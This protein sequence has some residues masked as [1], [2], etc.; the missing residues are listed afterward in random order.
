MIRFRTHFALCIVLTLCAVNA[1]ASETRACVTNE[2]VTSYLKSN[3]HWSIVKLSDLS[4]DDQILWKRHHHGLCPGMAPGRLDSGH[5]WY[6]LALLNKTKGK[7]QEKLVL[8]KVNGSKV[9]SHLL[10]APQTIVEPFVVWRTGSGTYLDR[11]TEKQTVIRHDSFIY[12]KMESAS[13]QFYLQDGRIHKL[14]AAY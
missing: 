1:Y 4:I 9:T 12:E 10:S 13:V 11:S 6:A 14:I 5:V 3:P 7:V 2:V 8:L